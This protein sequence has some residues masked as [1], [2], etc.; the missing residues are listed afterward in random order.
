MAVQ[1]LPDLNMTPFDFSNDEYMVDPLQPSIDYGGGYLNMPF[2]IQ[3][4]QPQS[5]DNEYNDN[6]DQSQS[7]NQGQGNGGPFLSVQQP[8]SPDMNAITPRRAHFAHHTSDSNLNVPLYEDDNQSQ[9]AVSNSNSNSNGKVNLRY[10]S[11]SA[12]PDT[13]L[14]VDPSG[15]GG[16]DRRISYANANSARLDWP[17]DVDDSN[18]NGEQDGVIKAELSSPTKT[19]NG[20]AIPLSPLSPSNLA[21]TEASSPKIKS[22]V[23]RP[24]RRAR[25]VA[26]AFT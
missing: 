2:Y 26:S 21:P 10:V 6:T 12:F 13:P 7:Q 9:R 8:A 23:P 11:A 15:L 17:D 20:L 4:P 3:Q 5:G 22:P 1:I 24:G 18:G 25:S 14:S 19:N 16:L